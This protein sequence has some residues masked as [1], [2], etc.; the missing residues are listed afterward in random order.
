MD[1]RVHARGM[2]QMERSLRGTRGRTSWKKWGLTIIIVWDWAFEE[3]S[4]SELR[5]N[6]RMQLP[7]LPFPIAGSKALDSVESFL[8]VEPATCLSAS[9]VSTLVAPAFFLA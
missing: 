1:G 8:F 9:E 3:S 4:Q 2:K 6:K 5:S 7:S